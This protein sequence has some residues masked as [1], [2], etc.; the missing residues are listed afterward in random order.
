MELQYAKQR[1]DEYAEKALQA[2][3]SYDEG[4]VKEAMTNFVDYVIERSM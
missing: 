4:P 1:Q 3:S 2:I